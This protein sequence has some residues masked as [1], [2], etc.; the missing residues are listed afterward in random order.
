MKIPR[1]VSCLIFAASPVAAEAVGLWHSHASSSSALAASGRSTQ[2]L[3]REMQLPV[4]ELRDSFDPYASYCR[5][6]PNH[7]DLSGPNAVEYSSDILR[8]LQ[9][10]NASAN[11]AVAEA[12]DKELYD[13]EEYWAFPSRGAGDCEDIALFKRERLVGFGLP[14]GAMTV[15]IVHHRR[16]MFPHAVLLVE[17]TAG[18]YLLDNLANGIVLWHEAPYNFEARERPDGSWERF[19]QSIWTY[20]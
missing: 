7:C 12:S 1:I 2:A 5:R 10:Q 3:P 4:I 15:A 20:E 19:D 6:Y 13:L 17:T 9:V 11:N 8:L 18:T 14:R 16:D